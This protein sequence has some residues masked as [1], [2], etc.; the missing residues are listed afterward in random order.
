[1]SRNIKD[2]DIILTKFVFTNFVLLIF[3]PNLINSSIENDYITYFTKIGLQNGIGLLMTSTLTLLMNGFYKSEYKY[4]LVFWKT[5]NNL[6]GHRVFTEL[7]KKDQRIDYSELMKKYGPLPTEPDLQN[8]LWYKILKKYPDDETIL[9]SHR[10]FLLFRDLTSI[11][12]S[13]MIIFSILFVIAKLLNIDLNIL[14]FFIF[15][16]EYLILVII[17]RNKAERFVLNVIAHDI[18]NC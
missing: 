1:M 3:V 7:A 6:P 4:I 8:K 15:F 2:Y 11:A 13:L 17:T 10:D 9:Q 5:K 14:Y 16:L 18:N 12:F